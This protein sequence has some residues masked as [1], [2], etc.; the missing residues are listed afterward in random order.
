MLHIV[1]LHAPNIG[2]VAV[3]AGNDILVVHAFDA[4][5]VEEGNV[6]SGAFV[7]CASNGCSSSS[8]LSAAFNDVRL[9]TSLFLTSYAF[10]VF[11]HLA[12]EV[13]LR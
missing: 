4:H 13:S 1:A 12:I 2:G 11:R 3:Y 6:T 9:R 7:R 5:G 8:P 10:Q